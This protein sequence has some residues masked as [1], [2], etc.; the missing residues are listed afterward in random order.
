MNVWWKAY[1]VLRPTI[2]ISKETPLLVSE[3]KPSNLIKQIIKGK[4]NIPKFLS[5]WVI[6]RQFKKTDQIKTKN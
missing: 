3:I 2:Q 1:P 5:K 4:K 6:K